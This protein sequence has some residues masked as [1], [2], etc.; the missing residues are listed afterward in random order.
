LPSPLFVLIIL[1]SLGQALCRERAVT[2]I[3]KP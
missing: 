2:F 3:T 1:R